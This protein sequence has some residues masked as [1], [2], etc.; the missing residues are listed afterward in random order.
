MNNRFLYL[1]IVLFSLIVTLFACSDMR[2]E[3][4]PIDE[5]IS[6]I[7]QKHGS[8]LITQRNISFTFRGRDYEQRIEEGRSVKFRRFVEEGDTIVD[9]WIRTESFFER[10]ING[11]LVTVTD[12]AKQEHKSAINSVFHFTFLPLFLTNNAVNAEIIDTVSI[13]TDPY[14]KIKFTFN[15]D[16]ELDIPSTDNIYIYWINLNNKTLD[17]L[18]YEYFTNDGG[19]RFRKAYNRRSI[20]GITFQDYMNYRPRD[21]TVTLMTIDEAYNRREIEEVSKIVNTNIQVTRP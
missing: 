8:G 13:G 9:K 18:A 2:K 20:G 3:E 14:C 11:E 1:S 19:L 12:S 10:H 4:E 21:T 17:Y 7:K 15:K 16:V 6:H 5:L